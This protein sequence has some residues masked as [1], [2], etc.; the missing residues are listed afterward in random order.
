MVSTPRHI[1]TLDGV[2]GLAAFAVVLSHVPLI[3]P[4]A[5]WWPRAY[6]GDEAVA[7]F[8]ALSGFLMAYLYGG[9][10]LTTATAIDYLVHRFARIYPVYAL[11]VLLVAALSFLPQLS[12][13]QP[14]PSGFDLLRHLAM[15]GS[16]GV[17]WSIPPEIQFYLF[18]LLLW[19]VFSDIG[20]FAWLGGFIAA[21]CLVLAYFGFPGPGILLPSKLPYFLLGALA[22]RAY[23]LGLAAGRGPVEGMTS[24]FLLGFFFASRLVFPGFAP[25]WG[26]TTAAI[27]ACIVFLLA[28]EPAF[29]K[30]FFSTPALRLL[31]R[32]SF[33]LYLFHVPVMFLLRKGPL[34]AL[35][36]A[37]AILISL[38]AA[39]AAAMLS[40]RLI[41][42]PSRRLLVGL[43]QKGRTGAG[44]M[45]LHPQ[46][47]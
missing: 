24:L 4:E 45:A 18:F 8:F 26:L 28:A 33:S 41:E 35:A 29:A 36:P 39:L 5:A 7:L 1:A 22:G 21:G 32:I 11:A 30:A 46:E 31:G 13:V 38:L 47:P 44:K 23:G 34:A 37:P 43:W 14:I 17:F 15:L 20:R 25:F 42:M 2:R 19:L 16:S 10:E 40:N 27:A 9:K 6:I 12:Y 3:F